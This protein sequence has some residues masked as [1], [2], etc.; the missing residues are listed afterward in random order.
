MEKSGGRSLDAVVHR[1]HAVDD[2][3]RIK[4]LDCADNRIGKRLWTLFGA[5]HKTEIL[6][7]C[8]LK[9]HVDGWFGRS[10][11]RTF[12]D[13]AHNA[14]NITRFLRRRKRED[15]LLGQGAL[16]RQIQVRVCFVHNHT[17]R[18]GGI[19]CVRKPAASKSSA[20]NVAKYPWSTLRRLASLPSSITCSPTTRKLAVFPPFET[21]RIS[22]TPAD[23]TPGNTAIRP[24]SIL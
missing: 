10:V 11:E 1:L 21:G 17:S 4:L 13:I 12:L 18:G 14:N 16:F 23:F 2:D 15:D 6:I 5:C 19:V 9:R 20:C 8:L 24:S 3:L 7:G 22:V